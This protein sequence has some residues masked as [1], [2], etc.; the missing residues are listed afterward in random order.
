ML[1]L[2]AFVPRSKDMGG[3]YQCCQ[4]PRILTFGGRAAGQA[5]VGAV[6]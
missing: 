6:A 3:P 2:A 5:A 1:V 4:P